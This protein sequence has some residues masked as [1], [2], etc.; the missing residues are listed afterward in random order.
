MISFQLCLKV[1]GNKMAKKI[2]NGGKIRLRPLT[3]Q[4]ISFII[5]SNFDPKVLKWTANSELP[6]LK[7]KKADIKSLKNRIKKKPK[8]QKIFIIEVRNGRFWVP[9]GDCG[10]SEINEWS[11]N[12]V[13]F[14]SIIPHYW[15]EGYGTEA[16][17]L[18]FAYA[19]EEMHLHRIESHVAEF[20]T[21][22]IAFHKK[23]R[24]IEEG[25]KKEAGFQNCRFW[26]RIIFRLLESEW[27]KLTK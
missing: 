16:T 23:F 13:F 21:Q 6:D 25:R 3:K 8:N 17:K 26:D 9:I 4:D 24:F 12:A 22:S 18:L 11:R 15:G 10:L 27:E 20:N 14:I 5:D 2:L 1:G 19:F 7:T